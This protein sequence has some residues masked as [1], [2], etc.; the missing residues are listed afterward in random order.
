MAKK[1]KAAPAEEEIEQVEVADEGEAPARGRKVMLQ[2]PDSGE[3][4]ARKDVIVDAYNEGMSR[5][6]IRKMLEEKYGHSVPY[7]I[8][9]AATKHLPKQEKAEKPAKK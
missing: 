4:V 8:V 5:S 7:Q 2:D 6:D 1:N 9:F 3:E